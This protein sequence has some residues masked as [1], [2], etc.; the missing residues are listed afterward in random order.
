MEGRLA[1]EAALRLHVQDPVPY[2]HLAVHARAERDRPMESALYLARPEG[3][4][5]GA[6]G[7]GVVRAWEIM[8]RLKVAAR[9]VVLSGCE[10][11]RGEEVA[12]EGV[13]SLSWAFH[14]AGARSTVASMWPV[15][16]RATAALMARFYEGVMA[17]ESTAEAL[18]AAQ[19]AAAWPRGD[20]GTGPRPPYH[21]AAF[22]VMGDWR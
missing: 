7:D 15:A 18:R 9:V 17:G 12:G 20:R 8:D 10:T 21:W 19:E 6:A 2:L 13:L 5:S 1:T 14:V 3:G 4:T 11:A 16:D 22:R